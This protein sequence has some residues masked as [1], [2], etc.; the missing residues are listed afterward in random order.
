MFKSAAKGIPFK[1]ND[2]PHGFTE[3]AAAHFA[4]SQT[5]VDED[6]GYFFYFKAKLIGGELHFNLERVSF[7]PNLVKRNG[8]QHATT[9]TFEACSG[10]VD[11]NTRY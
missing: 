4:F 5:A 9:V 3:D 6:D 2:S 7:E 8:C 1:L 11:G 10:I